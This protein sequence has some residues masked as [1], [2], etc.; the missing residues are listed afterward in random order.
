MQNSIAMPH[1]LAPLTL[2][3]AQLGKEYRLYDSPRQRL[4]ALVTGRDTHHS[5]WALRNVSFALRRG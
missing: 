3:V 4:K 2:E 1:N 5:H